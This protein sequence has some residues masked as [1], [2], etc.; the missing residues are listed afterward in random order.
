MAIN[1]CIIGQGT[2]AG[3]GIWIQPPSSKEYCG[4]QNQLQL[5]ACLMQPASIQECADQNQPGLQLQRGANI[6][7]GLQNHLWQ[8]FC[9]C[10][11]IHPVLSIKKSQISQKWKNNMK[12]MWKNVKWTC[13][14]SS[15][16]YSGKG[17]TFGVLPMVL[18]SWWEISENGD[19]GSTQNFDAR[20]VSIVVWPGEP[21]SEKCLFLPQIQNSQ[22]FIIFESWHFSNFEI[23]HFQK[24]CISLFWITFPKMAP[25]GKPLCSWDAQR[26]SV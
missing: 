6:P 1:I 18:G 9:I 26:N 21:F 4:H 2:K 15:S 14:R 13:P 11:N 20:L 25:Q 10:W 5:W 16:W 19:R 22:K 3:E 17:T 7:H 24:V 12:I 8:Y 23:S